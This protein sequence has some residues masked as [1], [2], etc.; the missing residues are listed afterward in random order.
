MFEIDE[1][2][3][4]LFVT[5]KLDR[6]KKSLHFIVVNATVPSSTRKTRQLNAIAECKAHRFLAHLFSYVSVTKN[7]LADNQ[8]LVVVRV[9]DENDN[10]PVFQK[11]NPNNE[12]VFNVDWQANILRPI[13]RIEVHDPDEKSQ[14]KYSISPEDSFMI[15]ATHGVIYVKKSLSGLE[16][17][18]FDLVV[19]VS[20][21]KN[22]IST[23]V[24]VNDNNT[25]F[26]ATT[27]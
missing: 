20:D 25:Y 5:K 12:Y 21:G 4:D 15:N 17:E 1:N 26:G 24:K 6:E 14:L 11:R 19:S 3:G 9:I 8:A 10:P 7:K 2:T 22:E 16:Q 13:A 27:Q 23:P 18:V